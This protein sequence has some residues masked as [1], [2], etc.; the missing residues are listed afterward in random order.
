MLQ[1][2]E[3]LSER[4][5]ADAVRGRL[6]WNYALALELTERGFDFSVLSEFRDRLIDGA[7]SQHLLHAMLTTFRDLNLLKPRGCALG[8]TP[9]MCWRPCAAILRLERVTETL[10]AALNAL[11]ELA[12]D[13]VVSQITPEWFDRYR[14]GVED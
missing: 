4:Q 5:A 6:D 7:L 11:A 13:W 2:V 9:R 12:P 3:G 8:P 10:R 14:A 1:F